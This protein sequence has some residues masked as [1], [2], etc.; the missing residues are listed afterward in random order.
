MKNRQA[1][2]ENGLAMLLSQL[3][4]P[5]ADTQAENI[6]VNNQHLNF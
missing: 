5:S 1:E 2:E 6:K 4:D 3:E